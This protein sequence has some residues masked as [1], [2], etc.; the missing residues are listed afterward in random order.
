MWESS[1]GNPLFLRHLVEGSIDAG[2]LTRV[3][4]VWQLRGPTAVP[5]GLA[6]LLESRLDRPATT[7]YN[8]LKLLA[9]C[10][11]LDVDALT[12]LA[13]EDAVD[14]AEMRGLIRL[15]QDGPVLNARFSHPLFGD[16]V[17]SRVGTAAARRLRG[18]MVKM[19]R[20]RELDSAAQP[21][22][23]WR[24]CLS[25]A[26]RP[27]TPNCSS[28]RPRTRSFCPTFRWANGWRGRRSS[29]AAACG[30]RAAVTRA[31]VAG[32]PGGGR[33][34]PGRV[35]PGRPRRACSSC[36]GAFPGCRSCSGLGDVARAHEV[37][38]LL[39]SGCSTSLKL[40]VDA[41]VGAMAVHENKIDEGISRGRGGAG[42]SAR[43]QAGG[44]V[45][46]VR[47]GTGH[48]GGRARRRVRTDRR[49]VSCRAEGHRRHDP[50]DGA[51]LRRARPDL[52]RRTGSGR[53]ACAEYAEFSSAGQRLGWAIAK[54][55]AGLVATYR[56]EFP[57][58]ISSIEQALAAQPPWQRCLRGECRQRLLE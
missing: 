21:G 35:R 46:R 55:T 32:P 1:G 39:A 37:L 8:A 38:A 6:A 16:V 30:R 13:G 36:S 56:G 29:G 41:T 26:T 25:T 17:R 50:G 15:V 12:E 47:G 14:A 23:G 53:R 33:G 4:D 9:L 11:P 2:T 51:V 19:L 18:R 22:S 49:P 34:D 52:H 28:P 42:R 48:A 43:A 54:I 44:R 27:S 45:R 5:S 3:D 40:I 7:S 10:E 57:D 24:S 20:H 58:A 31:A